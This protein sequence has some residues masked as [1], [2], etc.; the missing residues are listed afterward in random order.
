M[1]LY[2]NTETGLLT[3][4][5]GATQP[6]RRLD[7]KQRDDLTLE[8]VPSEALGAGATG[9]F[10]AKADYGGNLCALDAAWSAPTTS[11]AGYI[12]EV[13]LATAEIDTLL[14][15]ATEATLKAEILWSS[16]GRTRRTQTFDLVVARAVYLGGEPPATSVPP[17]NFFH[18]SA[19]DNSVWRISILPNGQIERTLIP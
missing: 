5:A 15:S 16:G 7:A 1:K 19:S 11:G 10:A 4:S 2:L 18:L 3:A 8:I 17:P 14:T 9:T 12:F 6:L 13:S